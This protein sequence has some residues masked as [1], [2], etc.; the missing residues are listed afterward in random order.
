MRIGEDREYPRAQI[1][2][3]PV[4]IN[5][6][7]EV[8]DVFNTAVRA[9][10]DFAAVNPK[11][12]RDWLKEYDAIRPT[13]FSLLHPYPHTPFDPSNPEIILLGPA[14]D[15]LEPGEDTIRLKALSDSFVVIIDVPLN[16]VRQKKVPRS[17]VEKGV[18]LISQ[19]YNALMKQVVQL[20]RQAKK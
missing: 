20:T 11:T 17:I 8:R 7:Y 6:E 10:P 16:L 13:E 19:G 2:Y 15:D 5:A 1:Q 4:N 18:R 3:V 12:D 14:I 9:T